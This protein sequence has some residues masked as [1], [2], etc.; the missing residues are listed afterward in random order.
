[1][2]QMN[3]R[4][5]N[6]LQCCSKNWLR[7]QSSRA[8]P[9]L[10]AG[11]GQQLVRGSRRTTSRRNAARSTSSSRS[12]AGGSPRTPGR[13]TMPSASATVRPRRRVRRA[14]PASGS[15]ATGRRRLGAGRCWCAMS[16]LKSH[17]VGS[18]ECGSG[19][20]FGYFFVGH[21]L[22]VGEVEGDFDEGGV[23]HHQLLV[24]FANLYGE[25]FGLNVAEQRRKMVGVGRNNCRDELVE[26]LATICTCSQFRHYRHRDSTTAPD[27]STSIILIMGLLAF[28]IRHAEH[29]LLFSVPRNDAIVAADSML[30]IRRR[31]K[32][33]TK[34]R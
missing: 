17:C 3:G 11:V 8:V 6:R 5:W 30:S 21:R 29:S 27:F 15:R 14:G 32:A 31:L 24:E 12:A 22:P 20:P 9:G 28:G 16:P 34:E 33:D 7:S 1:M 18:S 25:I 13:Q 26:Q 4:W 23:G 2:C 10:A 19:R